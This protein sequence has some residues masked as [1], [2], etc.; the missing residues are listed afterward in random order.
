MAS[1]WLRGPGTR[2][3]T[4]A[5][6][7]LQP[8][9]PGSSAGQLGTAGQP[10]H[11]HELRI[12]GIPLP[13]HAFHRIARGHPP[14]GEDLLRSLQ[15]GAHSVCGTG[16]VAFIV[17][18]HAPVRGSER[19]AL[20]L[21]REG[22]EGHDGYPQILSPHHSCSP[23]ATWARPRRPP[24]TSRAWTRGPDAWTVD[25]MDVC[26]AEEIWC[27]GPGRGSGQ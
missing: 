26:V 11:L 13:F 1:R 22:E 23:S 2:S 16:W 12:T 17:V 6:E 7:D 14:A 15:P 3:A 21:V 18:G 10:S 25:E 8:R 19:G 4:K 9:E 20:L 24:V 5:H 27:G